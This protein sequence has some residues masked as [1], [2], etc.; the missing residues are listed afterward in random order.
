[1]DVKTMHESLARKK[2]STWSQNLTLEG[3]VT[4]AFL[5]K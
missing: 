3:I 5:T 4:N 2:V 1:M